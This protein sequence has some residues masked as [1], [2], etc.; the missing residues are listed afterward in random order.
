MGVEVE[1]PSA[2]LGPEQ[3]VRLTAAKGVVN[4]SM[5]WVPFFF[6]TLESAFDSSTTTL[7][8][9]LGIGEMAGLSTLLVGKRLDEGGERT[10][11]VAS[12]VSVAISGVVA[13][14]GSIVFFAIS[15][16]FLMLGAAHITVSGHAWISARAPYDRRARF[17][18]VFETSW[19]FGLLIGAPVMALL[20]GW[21]GWRGPFVAVAISATIGAVMLSRMVDTPRLAMVSEDV[22]QVSG[23][24]ARA[25]LLIGASVAV[26][27]AG[28]TT[29]V[30]VGTWLNDALGV[31]TGG[32]GLVAMAFGAA[33]LTASS[34]SA[35]FADR[36]GKR[37]STQAAL[38]FVLIGLAIMSVADA[39]LLIGGLG[40]V[41]FFLGFEYG[42]V[43]SFSLVSEAMPAARGRTLA[44]NNALGTVARGAG[45][46]AAGFLYDRYGIDG[47]IV[48]SAIAA[49][50]AFVLLFIAGHLR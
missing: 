23:F 33:E 42:I 45:A 11:M 22:A 40:L 16:V 31:S 14:Q 21:L 9:I 8:A 17:I 36:I 32:I 27:V 30:I 35:A 47:P 3:M 48:L 13:L 19:A 43:T 20:I 24:T 6:V 34:T 28:L 26:A 25:W 41:L 15:F 37:R 18:G 7:A 29:I 2:N 38:S 50:V 49:V 12:L 46:I 5:R 10:V 39:S 1:N 44:T 4:A